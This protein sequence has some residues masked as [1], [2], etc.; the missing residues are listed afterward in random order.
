MIGLLIG[1]AGFVLASA[2]L[3]YG[4]SAARTFVRLKL[5]YVEAAHG[6]KAPL[7]AGIAGLCAS[8][9]SGFQRFRIR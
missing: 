9:T 5:R 3:L 7:L 2:V 6:I 4:F 8:G 1:I